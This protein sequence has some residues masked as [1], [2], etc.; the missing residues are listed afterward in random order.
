MYGRYMFSSECGVSG[1][2]L[3]SG[4]RVR[5]LLQHPV[6]EEAMRPKIKRLTILVGG[7]G[8]W[9]DFEWAIANQ[10][11]SVHYIQHQHPM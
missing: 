11:R 5:I 2:M 1:F 3:F 6:Y 4:E 7:G 8:R 10:R 9:H